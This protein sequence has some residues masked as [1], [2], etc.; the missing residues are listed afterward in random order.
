[1]L[2]EGNPLED[3]LQVRNIHAV[4]MAGELYD[5]ERLDALL[6]EVEASAAAARAVGLGAPFRFR[7]RRDGQ[8]EIWTRY[9]R[10]VCRPPVRGWRKERVT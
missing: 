3:I 4:I 9:V 8:L 2:L 7:V 10:C 1:M 5:R 6:S